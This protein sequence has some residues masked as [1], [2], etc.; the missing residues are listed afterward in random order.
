MKTVV[1][2]CGKFSGR[3]DTMRMKI[4]T[5]YSVRALW[6]KIHHTHR[7]NKKSTKKLRD[8]VKKKTSDILNCSSSFSFSA[9]AYSFL[10]GEHLLK[11]TLRKFSTYYFT[12]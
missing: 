4:M 7:K 12:L 1:T 11:N 5:I 6:V 8:A 3:T 9:V 2:Y 10:S